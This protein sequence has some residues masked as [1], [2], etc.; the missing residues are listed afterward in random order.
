MLTLAGD[1]VVEP[2]LKFLWLSHQLTTTC[3]IMGALSYVLWQLASVADKI[4]DLVVFPQISAAVST[5]P[6]STSALEVKIARL[7]QRVS[8][9]TMKVNR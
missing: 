6:T 9:L 2:L 7:A 1:T 3:R 4:H 8:E 5:A